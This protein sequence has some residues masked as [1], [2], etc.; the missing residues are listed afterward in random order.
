MDRQ[1]FDTVIRIDSLLLTLSR[2]G[3]DSIRDRFI[4]NFFIDL[5]ENFFVCNFLD[6]RSLLGLGS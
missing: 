6:D 2:L 5:A 1:L 3:L 4:L